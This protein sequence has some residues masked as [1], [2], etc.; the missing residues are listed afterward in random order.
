MADAH[1]PIKRLRER[2]QE[3]YHQ[4]HL[5]EALKLAKLDFCPFC[6]PE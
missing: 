6:S 2:V 5:S 1:E 3:L 4:G